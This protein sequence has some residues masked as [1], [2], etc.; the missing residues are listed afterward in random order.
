MSQPDDTRPPPTS[1]AG[2]GLLCVAIGLYLLAGAARAFSGI[3][4]FFLPPQLDAI[5]ALL[6]W[7]PEPYG[8]YAAGAVVGL[9]GIGAVAGGIALWT[10]PAI[11]T[12]EGSPKA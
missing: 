10:K 3:W 12:D 9:L 8:T 2:G 5:A 11:R 1:T 4:P 6:S 7:L